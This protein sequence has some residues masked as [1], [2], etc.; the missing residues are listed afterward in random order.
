MVFVLVEVDGIDVVEFELI[1]ALP[2]FMS[3]IKVMTSLLSGLSF[4]TIS[5]A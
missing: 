3:L 1:E 5:K 4:A 2:A